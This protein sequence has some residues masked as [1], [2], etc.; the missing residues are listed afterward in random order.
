MFSLSVDYALQV[1][2]IFAFVLGSY[3]IVDL[4]KKD[5]PETRKFEIL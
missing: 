4:R 2:W 3:V 5:P 1:S